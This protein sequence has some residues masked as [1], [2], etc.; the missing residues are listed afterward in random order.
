LIITPASNAS[1]WRSNLNSGKIA[2]DRRLFRHRESEQ[3]IRRRIGA[4]FGRW[5]RSEAKQ[6]N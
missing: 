5:R 6:E 3:Y 1:R 4:G 2:E